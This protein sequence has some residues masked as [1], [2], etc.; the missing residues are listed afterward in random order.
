MVWQGITLHA[1]LEPSPGQGRP[2]ATTGSRTGSTKPRRRVHPSPP[3]QRRGR[4]SSAFVHTVPTFSARS[5]CPTRIAGSKPPG[6]RPGLELSAEQRDEIREGFKKKFAAARPGSKKAME[7][8]FRLLLL[9]RGD[10]VGGIN[11]DTMNC[12]NDGNVYNYPRYFCKL[13]DAGVARSEADVVSANRPT[14]VEA[15]R[16]LAKD[17]AQRQRVRGIAYAD[18]SRAKQLRLVEKHLANFMHGFDDFVSCLSTEREASA[19][20]VVHS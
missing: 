7:L 12:R 1:K 3:G 18:L 19:Q 11:P 13:Y 2:A 15:A 4:A 14:A 10:Y 5:A 9:N 16:A 8:H 6:R 20:M 17:A